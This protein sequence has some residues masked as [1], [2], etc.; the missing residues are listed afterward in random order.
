MFRGNSWLLILIVV[1]I[2]GATYLSTSNTISDG[3]KYVCYKCSSVYK[4]ESL[5]TLRLWSLLNRTEVIRTILCPKCQ[6]LKKIEKQSADGICM[7]CGK[8]VGKVEV[9]VKTDVKD[10]KVEQVSV[11]CDESA[12]KKEYKAGY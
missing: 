8:N 10:F 4:T 7:Y 11:V 6:N 9:K 5:I 12:K 1:A 2:I 3:R